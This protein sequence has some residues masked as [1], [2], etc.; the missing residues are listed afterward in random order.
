[1]ASS[2]AA[3][4]GAWLVVFCALALFFICSTPASAFCGFYVGKADAIAVQRCVAGH[5]GAAR[6][7]HGDQHGQ[8]LSRAADRVRAGRAG[9]DRARAQP[10]PHR[11]SQALRAHRRVQRAAARGVLR[12]GSMQR[13]EEGAV[14]AARPSRVRAGARRREVAPRPGARRD[15]RGDLH[16]RRVRHRDPVRHAVGRPRDV[17]AR[18]RLSHP[19]GCRQCAA[20]LHPPAD[21]VLRGEGQSRGAGADGRVV[22]AA[23]A[24]RVRVGPLHA[25]RSTR[26]AE[27]ARPAGPRAVR[28]HRQ[29]PRRDHQ[30]PDG[31]AAVQHGRSGVR[32]QRVRQDVQG[33]V[34]GAGRARGLPRDLHR[35][36]LGHE[37]VRPVRCG[38]A[39]GGRAALGGRVLGRATT[40]CAAAASR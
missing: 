4:A 38:T 6:Q 20:S 7:P 9:P 19:Q 40:R 33:V 13:R 26:H 17:A 5:H 28:P 16:R 21:E 35:V 12:S 14:D 23:A 22:P 39:V 18:E 31:Q 27:C 8:R 10:D 3:R 24:V 36:F 32:P 2:F 29:R 30:L 25:A 15:R 11:R 37:L 1:M 34:P